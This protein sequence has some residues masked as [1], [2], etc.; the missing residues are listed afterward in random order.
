[1]PDSWEDGDP[2]NPYL[3]DDPRET[4][5]RAY[6]NPATNGLL[7]CLLPGVPM[8]FLNANHRSPWGFVRDTD[9]DWNVKVV[10]DEHNLLEWQVGPEHYDDERFFTH[11]RDLG[12]ETRDQLAAFVHTL[13][14]VGEATD[15]DRD[16]MATMLATRDPPLADG[17]PTAADLDAFA[18]AWMQ[19]VHEFAT[20]DHWRD[21]QDPDR[22]AF[23]RRLREFR[24]DRPWLRR[25]LGDEE[26]FGYRHPT[27]GAV[28]YYGHRV[29]PDGSA[30]V[31]F[32]GNME[33]MTESVT[34]TDLVGVDGDGWDL[35][36]ASPDAEAGAVDEPV[37]LP[38]AAMVVFT[39]S[40]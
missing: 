24:Q 23:D 19:D 10:A 39:R 32:V 40:V 29:A 26:T 5:D 28:L 30:E 2:I 38:N 15:Y 12:F 16:A 35:A 3:G 9:A 27:D 22:T 11:L 17:D 13:A 4:L 6:D 25:D 8:D 34:P 1:V 31:L 37:R 7:H 33:G 36:V 21:A 18:T 14:S 20:V